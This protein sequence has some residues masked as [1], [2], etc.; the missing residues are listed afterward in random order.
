MKIAVLV[1]LKLSNH[2]GGHVKYWERLSEALTNL[3]HDLKLTIFF[4][5]KLLKKINM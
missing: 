4:L 5:G 1:D 2:S 3:N